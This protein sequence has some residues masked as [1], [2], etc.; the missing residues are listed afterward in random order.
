MSDGIKWEVSDVREYPVHG[1]ECVTILGL[2]YHLELEDQ[3][4]LLARAATAPLVIV[5]THY[6]VNPKATVG[7]YEGQ[8]FE[9][10][11]SEPTASWGNERSFWP[12]KEGLIDMFYRSGYTHV[13]ELAPPYHPNRNFFMAR[14]GGST[15]L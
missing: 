14:G 2:L 7:A 4:D 13:W 1:Y 6:S 12:T 9:E 11:V 5:D 3:L 10:V 8:W 15:G